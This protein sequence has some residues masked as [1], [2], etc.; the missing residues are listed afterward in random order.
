MH[1][2]IGSVGGTS[3]SGE[4]WIVSSHMFLYVDLM[5]FQCFYSIGT[6]AGQRSGRSGLLAECP[7]R[8]RRSGRGLMRFVRSHASLRLLPNQYIVKHRK[9]VRG[10]HWWL[11]GLSASPFIYPSI[12]QP[13]EQRRH[14]DLPRSK[15]PWIVVCACLRCIEAWLQPPRYS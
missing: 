13:L 3:S 11:T 4:Y 5:R 7:M 1:R 2:S 14:W 12:N 6:G 15:R 10:V 8:R 9:Q